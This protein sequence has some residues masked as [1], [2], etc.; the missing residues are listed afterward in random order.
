[1]ISIQKNANALVIRFD[2]IDSLDARVSARLKAELDQIMEA[3][4]YKIAV[5]LT[6]IDFIDSSGFG[7][8]ISLL[9]KVR[10]AGGQ[11]FLCGLNSEVRDLM[12]ILQLEQ[13]FVVKSTVEEAL[14]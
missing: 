4:S 11:L 8:L 12:T 10:T 7:A 6:N 9:K 2:G 3:N 1:M 13:V 5:D 14:S